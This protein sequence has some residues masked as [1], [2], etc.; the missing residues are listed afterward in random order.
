MASKTQMTCGSVVTVSIATIATRFGRL[1]FA[2]FLIAVATACCSKA[3]PTKDEL[4]AQA[5]DDLAAEQ[6][7]RAETRYREI[8]RVAPDDPEAR[9][10]LALIYY[11]QGQ[12]PQAYPLLKK[13]AARAQ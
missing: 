3:P 11:D 5:K 13:A 7:L 12:L 10:Q 6:Y 1:A 8:L 2:F 4:L 9:R